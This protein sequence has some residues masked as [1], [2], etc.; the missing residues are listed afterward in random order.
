MLRQYAMVS[1]RTISPRRLL[2]ASEKAHSSCDRGPERLD[3]SGCQQPQRSPASKGPRGQL[4]R[5][6]GLLNTYGLSLGMEG[7]HP[8]ATP[9]PIVTQVLALSATLSRH[10]C[11]LRGCPS[12]KRQD[13]GIMAQGFPTRGESS[14]TPWTKPRIFCAIFTVPLW[15]SPLIQRACFTE[16]ATL[17]RSRDLESSTFRQR[18]LALTETRLVGQD[19]KNVLSHVLVW[20]CVVYEFSS[21]RQAG[22]CRPPGAVRDACQQGSQGHR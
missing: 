1:Y 11:P 9:S 14:T 2:F 3:S 5:G 6:R 21:S 12:D 8:K 20:P 4:C 15:T 7:H 22:I 16:V 17:Y 10:Q 18:S 19:F 13:S